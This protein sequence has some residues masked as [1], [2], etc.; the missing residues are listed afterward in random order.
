MPHA[1]LADGRVVRIQHLAFYKKDPGRPRSGYLQVLT[2]AGWTQVHS[3][4]FPYHDH[5]SDEDAVKEVETVYA[6]LKTYADFLFV[7]KAP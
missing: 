3:V 7:A 4:L 2:V 5:L 6:S 1:R